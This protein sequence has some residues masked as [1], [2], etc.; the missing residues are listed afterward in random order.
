M[1]E[2]TEVKDGLYY[3]EEHEWALIEDETVTI[4]ITDYAQ[5]SLHEITFVEISGLGD[6]INAGDE[7]GFVESMKASSEIYSPLSGEIVDINDD[8]EDAPELLNEDPYGEGWL[9]KLKASALDDE[10]NDLMDAQAY[11]EYI[12]SL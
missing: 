4:G 9:F 7:C 2:D 11:A 1:S 12:D 5:N 3:S 6:E 8:L 10:L